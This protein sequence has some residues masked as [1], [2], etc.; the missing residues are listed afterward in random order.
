MFPAL[1][2][3][4]S[5]LCRHLGAA[6]CGGPCPQTQQSPG[7]PARPCQ[8]WG[9]EGSRPGVGATR[10]APP[11]GLLTRGWF[12]ARPRDGVSSPSR[13][14]EKTLASRAPDRRRLHPS[15]GPQLQ[16]L[17][18]HLGS[19]AASPVTGG[20]LSACLGQRQL[21]Q[22]SECAHARMNKRTQTAS[23]TW[24]SGRVPQEPRPSGWGQRLEGVLVPFTFLRGTFLPGKA[25]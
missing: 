14:D 22:L 12:G 4:P 16:G 9:L 11:C 10:P 23:A 24:G 2:L 3:G 19:R 8:L 5:L 25:P 6:D 1:A 13:K 7:P 20:S 21:P 15:V 18:Q 17:S